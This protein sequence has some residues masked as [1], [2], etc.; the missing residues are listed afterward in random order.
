MSEKDKWKFN[1]SFWPSVQVI[2]LPWA[3]LERRMKRSRAG[4]GSWPCGVHTESRVCECLCTRLERGD[5]G[6]HDRGARK[7]NGWSEWTG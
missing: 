5:Q 1:F 6:V 7:A 2:A 4:A 3:H